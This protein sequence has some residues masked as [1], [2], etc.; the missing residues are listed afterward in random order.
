MAKKPSSKQKIMIDLKRLNELN[1]DGCPACG[2]GFTLGETAVV[3][4]GAWEGG[5][6]LIHENEAVWDTENR[7]YVERRCFET[8]RGKIG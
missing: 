2:R 7:N 4:C 3:A 5:A 8:R 6:K 1:T